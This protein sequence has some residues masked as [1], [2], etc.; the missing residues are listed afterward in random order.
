[1]LIQLTGGFCLQCW[2][3]MM[4]VIAVLL[5]ISKR[6]Q[7][8]V[9]NDPNYFS[10]GTL[11][12]VERERSC[13]RVLPVLPTLASTPNVAVSFFFDIRLRNTCEFGLD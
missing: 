7:E 13:M 8:C 5:T 6:K 4:F 10:I 1:M 9:Y 3:N 11:A 12:S 2:E